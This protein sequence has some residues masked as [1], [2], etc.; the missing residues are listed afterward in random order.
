MAARQ[1]HALQFAESVARPVLRIAGF[2]SQYVATELG[3]L[4]AT[5]ASGRGQ[6]PT[7]VLAHGLGAAST[8]FVPLML[9]L[10]PH[11][12]SIVAID[13]PG[14]GLSERTQRSPELMEIYDAFRSAVFS[15]TD[16]PVSLLGNSFGGALSIRLA[17]ECPERIGSLTLLSPAG[18]ALAPGA[19]REV[20]SAFEMKSVTDAREFIARVYH[21]RPWYTGLVA[22]D[23]LA[24]T[25]N[26]AVRG[27]LAQADQDPG[28]SPVELRSLPM[29]IL[30]W[31]GKSERIF[32]AEALTY[33]RTHLPEHA[34]IEQPDGIGHC[35]HVEAP[36]RTAHRLL[37]FWRE[38][39]ERQRAQA[40]H[41]PK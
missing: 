4:H 21:R 18:A 22:R 7:V 25:Q 24:L 13:M 8:N 14:H 35:A 9:A 31:W 19:M 26:E 38:A 37:A 39:A 5:V 40:A 17:S 1:P 23:V 20:T 6:L 33:F 16:S 3:T 28:L 34:V 36:R 30:L 41:L 11:V 29:P 10:Q 27:V 2:R 12:R 32:P 15:L